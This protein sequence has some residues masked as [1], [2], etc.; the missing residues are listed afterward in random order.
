VPTGASTSAPSTVEIERRTAGETTPRAGGSTT[1]RRSRFRPFS[2]IF[3]LQQMRDAARL[4]PRPS[5]P[6]CTLRRP[7]LTTTF[8]VVRVMIAETSFLPFPA[9]PLEFEHSTRH[10]RAGGGSRPNAGSIGVDSGGY[11]AFGPR[12]GAG[13]P[14]PAAVTSPSARIINVVRF[15]RWCPRTF[16][17]ADEN[18]SIL[19]LAM[20][21]SLLRPGRRRT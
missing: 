5:R 16:F 17:A 13:E 19:L 14:Q 11:G 12:G 4:I 15:S 1:A 9:I 6:R 10:G 2:G 7:V 20:G 8:A 18:W 3:T 21:R